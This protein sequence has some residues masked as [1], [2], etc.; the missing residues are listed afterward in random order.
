MTPFAQLSPVEKSA[1]AALGKYAWRGLKSLFN[2]G[3][4]GSA[5]KLVDK[6]QARSW[7]GQ[8][9][10][11]ALGG[12]SKIMRG[13]VGQG[14]GLYGLGGMVTEMAGGPSLPGSTYAMYAGM[15]G[16]AAMMGTGN[17]ML[18][19]RAGSDK[20]RQ[21]M[22][23]DV[24][25]GAQMAGGDFLTAMQQSGGRLDLDGYNQFLRDNG[26]YMGM[27]DQYRTGS[28]NPMGINS[29]FK[30]WLENPQQIINDRMDREIFGR[31][32]KG[33]SGGKAA[34][35]KGLWKG[36]KNVGGH[37]LKWMTPVF[38]AG[39]IGYGMF[40]KPYDEDEAITRGYAAGQAGIQQKLQ[41]MSGFE[42]MMLGLDPSLAAHG[43]E[44]AIPGTIGAWQGRGDGH[45]SPGWI[46]RMTGMV[47]AGYSSQKDHTPRYYEMDAAGRPHYV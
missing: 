6:A 39:A 35:A 24:T 19:A 12:A 14:L 8:P 34:L 16:L 3:V 45:Y 27:A 32:Q 43:V 17:S 30:S 28:Y 7:A 10:W 44:S 15:P 26:R 21:A 1:K 11:S 22:K 29:T 18:L 5:G 36:T 25:S 31:M 42:R 37:A 2:N 23:N 13:K 41:G 38:G 9:A 4:W 20:H 40:G 46:S 33:A 47:P